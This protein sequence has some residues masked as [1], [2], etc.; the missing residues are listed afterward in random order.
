MG[1]TVE[2]VLASY[3]AEVQARLRQMRALILEVAANEDIDVEETLKW[4]QPSYLAK[5]GSTLRLGEV[6]GQPALFAH[7]Q[8]QIIPNARM[9]FGDSLTYSGNRAVILNDHA[10]EG[11]LRQIVLHGLTYHQGRA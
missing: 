2:T 10:G 11:E 6:D 9:M 8:S 4:G 3:P 7:C 5:K 1:K